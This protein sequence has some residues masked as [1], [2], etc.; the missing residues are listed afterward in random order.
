ME[1]HSRQTSKKT[2]P[3]FWINR[4]LTRSKQS[5]QFHGKNLDHPECSLTSSSLTTHGSCLRYGKINV[6][7]Y[8]SSQILPQKLNA[9]NEPRKRSFFENHHFRSCNHHTKSLSTFCISETRKTFIHCPERIAL[10][11][12]IACSVDAWAGSVGQHLQMEGNRNLAIEIVFL[13]LCMI[14]MFPISRNS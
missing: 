12:G 10:P 4:P 8:C 13:T 7:S 9:Q 14:F 6:Y 2:L 1:G 11:E 5:N 3:T